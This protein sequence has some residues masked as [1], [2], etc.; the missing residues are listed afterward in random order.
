MVVPCILLLILS[1]P[2]SAVR[3]RK[4]P[5]PQPRSFG[6]G[7]HNGAGAD[8]ILLSRS[9]SRAIR[10]CA[11]ERLSSVW[12]ESVGS[13]WSH[14]HTYN[15]GPSRASRKCECVFGYSEDIGYDRTHS[16][17]VVSFPDLSIALHYYKTKKKRVYVS[18]CGSRPA[19]LCTNCFVSPG[20]K[21]SPPHWLMSHLDI[22]PP[23]VRI[24]R[25]RGSE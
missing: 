13:V 1:W 14:F 6:S 7:V 3:Y 12:A 25:R 24:P 17:P 4:P 11:D 20:Y 21:S 15:L 8:G 22:D 10:S 23:T 19:C 5:T 16:C 2:R 18:Q 9:P